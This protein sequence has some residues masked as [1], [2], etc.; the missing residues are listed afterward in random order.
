MLKEKAYTEFRS[1]NI[2]RLFNLQMNFSSEKSL[3]RYIFKLK[4]P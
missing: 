1:A 2:F 3:I 4:A